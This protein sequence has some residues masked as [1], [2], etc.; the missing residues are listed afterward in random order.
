MAARQFWRLLN[1]Y[2]LA[3][4]KIPDQFTKSYVCHIYTRLLSHQ[5][6]AL[7]LTRILF[8]CTCLSTVPRSYLHKSAQLSVTPCLA[9]IMDTDYL[10]VLLTLVVWPVLLQWSP[11][12]NSSYLQVSLS[13]ISSNTPTISVWIKYSPVT[14]C[15]PSV[16][17]ALPHTPLRLHPDSAIIPGNQKMIIITIEHSDCAVIYLLCLPAKRLINACLDSLFSASQSSYILTM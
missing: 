11:L 5:H 14:N 3:Q 16:V 9:S 17:C 7:P 4:V 12:L 6:A 10:P 15:A 2:F 13:H 8:T 1:D